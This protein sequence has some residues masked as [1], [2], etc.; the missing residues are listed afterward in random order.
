MHRFESILELK[1]LFSVVLAKVDYDFFFFASVLILLSSQF[2]RQN[3]V[4][5]KIQ[6]PLA[7]ATRLYPISRAV[8]ASS[9]SQTQ[10]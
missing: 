1:T 8:R 7:R 10:I 2:D 6:E 3:V 9:L 5:Q 4:S